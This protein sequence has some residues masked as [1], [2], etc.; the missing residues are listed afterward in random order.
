MTTPTELEAIAGKLTK[1]QREA[2][3]GAFSV[4]EGR[5]ASKYSTGS[6]FDL[7]RDGFA[8]ASGAWAVLTPLGLALRAHLLSTEKMRK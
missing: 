2:I 7:E 1:A 5:W 3:E 6:V 4:S 8:V